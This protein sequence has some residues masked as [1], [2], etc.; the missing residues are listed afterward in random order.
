MQQHIMP[1]F[2][3]ALIAAAALFVLTSCGG[4]GPLTAPDDPRAL[5]QAPPQ[6][7]PPGP[8][9]DVGKPVGSI[10]IVTEVGPVVAGAQ[11]ALEARVTDK[12][13][14]PMPD[15]L[16]TWSST[17]GGAFDPETAVTDADGMAA[18]TFIPATAAGTEH[19]ITAAA[20]LQADQRTITVLAG[21]PAALA[22]LLEDELQV[23][24]GT[25]LY[26]AVQITDAYGNA[27]ALNGYAIDWEVRDIF[28]E[29]FDNTT[30]TN[31]D[32]VATVLW[33]LSAKAPEYQE[34][35]ASAPALGGALVRFRFET[36]PDVPVW[37]EID[38]D[39]VAMA[40]SQGTVRQFYALVLDQYDNAI[41]DADIS[42]TIDTPVITLTPAG[43]NSVRATVNVD[44]QEPIIT[45]LWATVN[46]FQAVARVE[47]DP[48]F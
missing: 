5:V 15:R 3:G 17:N 32:G 11:L 21:P 34:L 40:G 1:G 35:Q 37:I 28:S 26:P 7:V 20:G 6:G 24:A 19:D 12:K 2:R 31:A 39:D 8:P 48:V 43:P 4:D 29:V 44:V 46:G 30:H 47:I 23:T 13:G 45:T 10:Q 27:L 9:E 16:V 14:Q 36:V 18:T 42:W 33:M 41:Q 38:P 22:K 25:E